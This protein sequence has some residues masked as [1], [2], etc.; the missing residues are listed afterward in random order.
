MAPTELQS[1]V[2]ESHLQR[3][4]ASPGFVRNE[5]MSRF[6]RFIVEQQ[7]KGREEELKESLI[8]IEVFGRKPGYDP[9]QD[10]IVRSEAARSRARLAEYYASDGRE[11]AL[12]IDLPKGGYVPRFRHAE[13]PPPS[14]P[15]TLKEGRTWRYRPW[16]V[17][18][19][20]GL[21][22]IVFVAVGWW[23]WQYG[24]G[25]IP[26]AVLPLTNLSQDPAEDYLADGITDELIRNLSIIDGLAV[27]SQTSSFVFKGKAQNVRDAGKQLNVDYILEG[28]TFRAGQQLRVNVQL[29]RVRDDF[30][31]WS[32]TYNRE[33]TEIVAIQGRGDFPGVSSTVCG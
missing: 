1:E 9:Q 15:Q 6:L 10:S 17:A 5:R 30:P 2:V 23:H 20:G 16:L 32:G 33:V 18:V 31:M 12:V 11:D 7:L 25:P 3:V 8:G 14:P 26:I 27:R 28:N 29:I 21:M 19:L 24:G 13:A 4:L 22:M